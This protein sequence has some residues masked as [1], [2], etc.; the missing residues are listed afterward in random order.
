MNHVTLKTE[1]TEIKFPLPFLTPQIIVKA[2]GDEETIKF[3]S[4]IPTMKYTEENAIGFMEFLK[5][6]EE[7]DYE[8]R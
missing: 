1:R 4:A 3:M 2:I 5:Y 6:T 7:L 8:I